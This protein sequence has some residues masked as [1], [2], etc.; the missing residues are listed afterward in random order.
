MTAIFSLLATAMRA[1]W[2]LLIIYIFMSWLPNARESQF[3]QMLGKICEPYLEIFR[4]FI[5]PI[6]MLDLSALVGIILLSF[7]ASAGVP[8]LHDMV[9]S[10]F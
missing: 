7:A 9:L 4:E 8:A 3:G 10:L 5:P 2:F 1:Y 6:G